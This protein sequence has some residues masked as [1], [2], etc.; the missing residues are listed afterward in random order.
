MANGLTA[1]ALL[2]AKGTSLLPGLMK[3]KRKSKFLK[4]EPC[5]QCG[6]KDNAARFSDGHLYCYSCDAVIEKSPQPER[7]PRYQPTPEPKVELL[8]FVKPLA[9]ERRG[10]TL[11]TTKLFEYGTTTHNNELVQVATYR[12]QLGKKAA[13]HLRYKDKRFRWIG[14]TNQLQLFG[15]H[16][17]RQNHGNGTN[18]FCVVTEGEI[19]AMSVS[20]VQGNKFPVVSL[21]NGAS[22]ARKYLAANLQWLSQFNRIVLCFDSDDP[23]V[24]AAE[25]AMSVLPLGKAAICR[26]PRKD[27]NEMLVAGE[28]EHLRDLLWKATPVRPDGII[29]ASELWEELVK[30]G[31]SA[32][33]QYPWP[34]LNAAAHGFRKGEM[35]TLAAGSG[36]GKSSI[37][38]EWIVHFLRAGLKVGVFMLEESMQRSLQGIVGVDISMPIHLE[39]ELVKDP[40][41]RTAFDELMSTGNLFLYDHFGSMDPDRLVEQIKYLATSEGVDVVVVDH[42]TIVVSGISDLDE[43]R[44]L[45]VTCT[46]LRQVVEQTGVGLVLVSHLKRP[47]GR[48][49][50]EGGQTSLSQLRGSHAIAQLSD[51]CIGAERNQQGGDDER[52]KL[53]LR[54]LKNRFSGE[55]GPLDQLVFDRKTGRLSVPMSS[56]F[57]L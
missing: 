11:D 42:L 20:Q 30:P 3:E 40:K 39:P 56:Y 31:A 32:V 14:S 6:S 35:V 9:L 33:C 45:D 48:G 25:D 54:M 12:D 43:R 55:T 51:L 49:H 1:M 24:A 18:M 23:G 53:Q 28:G 13:Q 17:W 26:L 15:Q 21:P 57:G 22:S 2:G 52:N 27:A 37:C 47:E 19:D 4:H 16:L 44:A 46:K 36:A 34:K 50:E 41:V 38:R 8:N 10:L 5:P 29:N 7:L